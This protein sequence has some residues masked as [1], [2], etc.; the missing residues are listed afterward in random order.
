MGKNHRRSKWGVCIFKNTQ[1]ETTCNSCESPSTIPV[2]MG[3]RIWDEIWKASSMVVKFMALAFLI[4]ALITFYVPEDFMNKI[5]GINGT[6]SVVIAALIGIP[7]YTSNITA[8]PLIS[9][10]L[11]MG[12]NPGAALSFLIAGPTTTLPAMIAVWGIA[13]RKVF[14]LY[15]AFSFIG[16]LLFG[17]LY[18]LFN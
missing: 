11:T 18:I 13:R 14:L 9:G 17:F 15:I 10:L 3:K 4:N 8:L 6:F 2:S 5:L 1:T 7:A 16:A 12:M